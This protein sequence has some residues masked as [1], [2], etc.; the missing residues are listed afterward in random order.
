[1]LCLIAESKTMNVG[2]ADVSTEQ[3]DTYCP[4]F[5]READEIM[6]SLREKTP[7]EIADAVRISGAL[8][9]RACNM[10]YDFPD[11]SIGMKAIEA[12]TG[13]V[14]KALDYESFSEDETNWAVGKIGIISSLYGYLG[15]NDIVKPYRLDFTTR[16][17][18]GNISFSAYWRKKLT[19][20]IIH[21]LQ[22]SGQTEV[23]DLMPADAAKC[24][25]F[26]RLSTL[27]RIIKVDFK[28]LL[29]GGTMRT[30]RAN[31]LKTLRGQL[32]RLI[33]ANRIES[34][35]D[36]HTMQTDIFAV[37]SDSTPEMLRLIV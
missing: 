5:E 19:E 6:N 16:L 11:K 20:Y 14:Y 30:P 21:T 37:D 8:A 15:P 1:M 2:S 32:L 24:L 3:F 28:E 9:S 36:L 27:A 10:I 7:A 34:S 17:A 13:V 35:E 23:L 33:V 18:P 25:D 12:Y 22:S 29:P 4:V 31:H 26:K